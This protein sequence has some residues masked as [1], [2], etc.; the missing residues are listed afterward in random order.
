MHITFHLKIL[1]WLVRI[2]LGRLFVPS[3]HLTTEPWLFI[4]RLLQVSVHRREIWSPKE[5]C[6]GWRL[7]ADK[8]W[9]LIPGKCAKDDF[10]KLVYCTCTK[11]R[12]QICSPHQ[13]PQ[14]KPFF[15]TAEVMSHV[16]WPPERYLQMGFSGHGGPLKA[17][18][19]QPGL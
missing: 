13:I 5:L 16:K 12:K 14:I 3:M 1:D 7:W 15:I 9:S 10:G 11:K 17:G 8:H 6:M 18:V 2:E 19:F 4:T